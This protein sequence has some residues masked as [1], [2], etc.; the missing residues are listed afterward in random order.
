MLF[1]ISIVINISPTK[2]YAHDA[3]FLQ[4]LINKDTLQYYGAV[5]EDKAS[6]F[7]SEAKHIEATIYGNSGLIEMPFTFPPK[8]TVN[9]FGS[10]NNAGTKDVDRAYEVLGTLLPNLNQ[11]LLALN[12]FKPYDS[13]DELISASNKLIGMVGNN[14][15]ITITSDGVDY[16]FQARMRKGYSGSNKD[17][18]G[19]FYYNDVE[20][21]TIADLAQQG[22]YV[23]TKYG[24]FSEDANFYNKPG[25]LEVKISEFLGGFINGIRSFLGLYSLNELIFSEGLRGTKAFYMGVMPIEWMKDATMFHMIFQAL[26]WTI[27]VVAITKLL[28]QRNLATINPSIRISL[29]AGIKNLISTAFLLTSIFLILNSL[30]M[31]NLKLVELFRTVLPDYVAFGGK[32]GDYQTVA[33][34]ILQMFYLFV[35][36]VLNIMYIYRA[37]ILAVLIASAPFFIVSL[38]FGGNKQMFVTW[39]K[40]VVAN[41]FVQSIHAFMFSLFLGLQMT[42]RG[43]EI[44][45]IS[46]ALIPVTKFFRGLIMGNS[47]AFAEMQSSSAT[48]M[49]AGAIGSAV[50]GFVGAKKGSNG[51]SSNSGFTPP[52]T[53]SK[54]TGKAEP[55]PTWTEDGKN[56]NSKPSSSVGSRANSSAGGTSS[57]T[58]GAGEAGGT[59]S[60]STPNSNNLSKNI[61]NITKEA[62]GTAGRTAVGLGKIATG[63]AINMA[64]GGDFG[65]KLIES[66]A[67]NIK[68]S[69]SKEAKS[70]IKGATSKAVST[71]KN[72]LKE[73][74]NKANNTRNKN[75]DMDDRM[76]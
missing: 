51:G 41:I 33:G 27:I 62:S 34:S 37:I 1:L 59:K 7:N 23:A 56:I 38:S 6:M 72:S 9:A 20:Y 64:T 26:A 66:G 53:I 12:D 57:E 2:T 42:T 75:I 63:T 4:V 49:M 28:I 73:T 19:E 8:E 21:L 61:K 13:V 15:Y 43:I 16:Q 74:I 55:L 52:V 54:A 71:T 5:I 30:L 40:E 39:A 44:A 68:N 32:G 17:I 14:D 47:G 58:K 25:W 46:F 60:K 50:G 45:V 31:L 11:A 24:H 29:M 3:Y 67:G 69:L 36:V 48:G 22:I 18:A 10:K 70:G 65:G 76:F 35:T